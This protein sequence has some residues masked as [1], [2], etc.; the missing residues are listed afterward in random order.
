MEEERSSYRQCKELGKIAIGLAKLKGRNG[1]LT[2][3]KMTSY[4]EDGM[5]DRV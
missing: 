1:D 4:E 5:A 2:S 3:R